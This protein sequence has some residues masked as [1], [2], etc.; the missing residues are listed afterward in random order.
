[1]A[2]LMLLAVLAA[3]PTPAAAP[4]HLA[5]VGFSAVRIPA[6][7]AASFSETFALRLNQTKL[8]QVI[9]PRDAAAVLGGERQRQLLGC[10]DDGTSCLAELAGALGADGIVTGEIAQVGSV[11]QLTVKV[12]GARDAKVLFETLERFK[13]E[14]EVLD[15]LDRIAKVAAAQVVE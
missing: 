4:P 13:S 7:L 15:A 8:V 6:D 14:E 5:A 1:M 10:S 3:D 9:T 2:P 12:L 11:I